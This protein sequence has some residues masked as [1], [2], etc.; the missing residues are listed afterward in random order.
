MLPCPPGN[1]LHNE[2]QCDTNDV[3]IVDCFENYTAIILHVRY[4]DFVD[5]TMRLASYIA[6]YLIAFI[7]SLAYGVTPSVAADWAIISVHL[8]TVSVLR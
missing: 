2:C 3:F 1:V 5:L 6:S 4:S 7:C 8:G